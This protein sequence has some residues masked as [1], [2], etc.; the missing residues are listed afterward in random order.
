MSKG[1][2]SFKQFEMLHFINFRKSYGSYLV[3]QMANL[4]VEEGI[5]WIKGINGSGKSTL[6]KA[7][8]GIIYFE[9]D[10]LLNTQV[11]IKKQSISYRRHV[12][13]AEAEPIYP[14][15]LTGKELLQL[16][17]SAKNAPVKDQQYLIE[18][19]NMGSYLDSDLGTY[20]SGMLKKLSLVLAFM[21]NPKLILL[22]EPLITI[23][24]QSLDTLYT[25]ITEKHKQ[26]GTN[27]L[28]SSHQALQFDDLPILK[29]L[30]V[31]QRTVTRL[32]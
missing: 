13:F 1:I 3:L 21:G 32:A 30:L 6:L 16:F 12:N 7:I 9:G 23:D 8:A 31:E 22:D 2:I 28:L 29:E 20:S 19:F 11:S 24:K 15:F 17:A 18:I 14:P 5:Y 25:L 27:F 26:E 10:I 4:V